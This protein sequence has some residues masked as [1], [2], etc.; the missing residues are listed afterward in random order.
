[1][2]SYQTD[3]LSVWKT[4]FAQF[5]GWGEEQILSWAKL[6]LEDLAIPGIVLN[7]PPL[8]YVARELVWSQPYCEKFSQAERDELIGVVL[9]VL[10][11]KHTLRVFP[12]GYDFD[13]TRNTLKTLLESEPAARR[14]LGR[15]KKLFRQVSEER[16]VRVW[17]ETLRHLLGWSDAR[18]SRNLIP[19][20]KKFRR[21]FSDMIRK[22]PVVWIADLLIPP[23]LQK[24]L[25]TTETKSLKEKLVA[26]IENGNF[27]WS[28]DESY[29]WQR[30]R[31][32]VHALLARYD[33]NGGS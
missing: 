1:M 13:K 27:M 5:L 31:D 19:L 26:A 10:S 17:R 20:K 11:M 7:K 2:N 29:D 30:A 23:A 21:R 33:V 8:Y 32:R 3:Y 18:I 9:D 14:A 16:Y 4:A 28:E 22:E 24:R 6:G 12:P 25:G 15:Q